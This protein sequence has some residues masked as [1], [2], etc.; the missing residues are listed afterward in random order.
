VYILDNSL[1][2]VPIGVVGELHIGGDGLSRGYLNRSELTAEKFIP[3]PFSEEEGDRIYKTGDLARYRPDGEIECLGRID[4][5]VKLR[6]FRI[7]LGEIE[8][9]MKDVEAINNCVVVLREDRPGDQRLAVYYVA[10]EGYT[11]SVSDLRS[12]LHTKLPDYMVPQHFVELPSIPLTPN[13]KVDRKALP[14]P[15]AEKLTE[16]PYVAPR[17]ETE[18]AITAIWREVLKID[19]VGIHDNFFELGGHSLL[20]VQVLSKVKDLIKQNVSMVTLFKYPT[21][22]SFCRSLTGF[23]AE[24][25]AFLKASVRAKR[26]QQML[27]RKR[28]MR[29]IQRGL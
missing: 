1:Q 26:Q 4:H 29:Q 18:R 11:V 7:E 19:Q 12:H 8:A 17:S 6:G 25:P 2:P 28:E 20:M 22:G 3:H 21:I 14:K 5:Q 15:E 24:R 10:R 27:M 23:Q 16:K 13:G 9:R